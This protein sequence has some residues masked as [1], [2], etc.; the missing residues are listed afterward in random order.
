MKYPRLLPESLIHSTFSLS[1]RDI[2]SG[3]PM[4][5]CSEIYSS[6]NALPNQLNR[7]RV[8]A[9]KICGIEAASAGHPIRQ[10]PQLPDLFSAAL[11]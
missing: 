2:A 9:S 1:I 7:A 6:G 10:G 11:S 3:K 8:S 4:P 5:L